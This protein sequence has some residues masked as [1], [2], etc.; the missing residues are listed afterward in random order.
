MHTL[1]LA[2]WCHEGSNARYA[3]TRTDHPSHAS[4]I[5]A[6]RLSRAAQVA[7]SLVSF[8]PRIGDPRGNSLRAA[9]AIL[10][11]SL[12]LVMI[13]QPEW[14][15]YA[16][17]GSFVSLYGRH[18]DHTPRA[19]MQ[20]A[21]GGALAATA[22]S[23]SL[24]AL[25]PGR[26]LLM[27]LG[28]AVVAVGGGLLSDVLNAHPPG[29]IYAVFCFGV[30]ANQPADPRLVGIAP[31]VLSAAA[32]FSIALGAL[33]ALRRRADEP[34]PWDLPRRAE[35]AASLRLSTVRAHAVRYGV[36]AGL[37]ATAATACGIGHPYWATMAAV[38][39]MSAPNTTK[40]IKRGLHRL[41]GTAAGLILAGCLLALHPRG[42][43][44]IVL[45][46]ALQAIAELF[47][48]RHYALGIL[49]VTPFALL[50][51]QLAHAVPLFPLL[52]DRALET[53]IGVAIALGMALLLN[54]QRVN[55]PPPWRR[56]EPR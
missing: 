40:R 36:G 33:G 4:H 41:A 18:H 56:P 30:C 20:A 45:I 39:P 53:L 15:V 38:I 37:A 35:I 26:P 22:V 48:L 24:V 27:I 17:F 8:E 9:L 3:R 16:I 2:W 23:G 28:T 55:H 21:W 7:S 5:A 50:V 54:D 12:L 13:G 43:A 1:P 47:I 6:V 10:G 52:R 11:P 19:I 31:A 49:F 14:S 44:A 29:P 25:L 51:G 34:S 42:L 46:A 32:L